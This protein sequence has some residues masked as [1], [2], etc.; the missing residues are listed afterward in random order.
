TFSTQVA[1]HNPTEVHCSVVNWEDDKLIVYD[2]TQGIF[3][4]RETV[5]KALGLSEEKVQVIKEYMGGGFGSKLEAGKYTVMAAILS[6]KIK[7]PV[8][9]TLDRR[10][11]NLAVGNRPDSIQKLKLGMKKDGTLTALSQETIASVG[12]YPSGGGCSWPLRTLYKCDNVETIEFSMLTNTGKARPF[13]APGHVQGT[14]A[15]E[16]LI[17]DAALKIDMDPIEF[18]LKNYVD[19]DQ[20]WGV[21]YSS[22]KLK[23]AY[24]IGAEK[25]GWQNRNKIPG[26]GKGYIKS[27]IGMATQI[28]WGGGGPPAHANIKI[29]KDGLVN[30]YSGTQDIGTG[31]YTFISQITAEILEVPLMNIIVHLGNTEY[32]YGPSSGGS[33]TA[34][35]ISPAVR[36]A[37][38]KMKR[39]L[40]SA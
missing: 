21:K 38:E 22:K 6:K 34:P 28:W 19:N 5:A 7:R 31:T 25:I 29:T 26:S 23:E 4:V 1:I 12:A 17:D 3:E 27:G 40:Y 15:F 32:P 13:R 37:A 36:D 24:K 8:K 30:V 18:R 10:E 35:S 20:V 39:K 33:T 14:F 11:M 2:S 9:I 16:A